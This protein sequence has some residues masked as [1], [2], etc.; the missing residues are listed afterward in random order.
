MRRH[1]AGSINEH[2]SKAD[3]KKK[4]KKDMLANVRGLGSKNLYNLQMLRLRNLATKARDIA[5]GL[6]EFPGN[7]ARSLAIQ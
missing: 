6:H 4:E 5:N 1:G 2:P 3:Q 7:E